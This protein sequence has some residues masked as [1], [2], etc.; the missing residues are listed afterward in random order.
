MHESALAVNLL[1][2]VASAAAANRISRVTRIVLR[3][4][5]MRM[6]VPELLAS[7]FEIAGVGSV[8][9]GAALEF[10]A[11]PAA[12]ICRACGARAGVE[13]W[14]F[15]CPSCGSGET[16]LES[17]GELDLVEMTGEQGEDA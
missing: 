4:G 6:V 12:M 5:A 17:G 9:E 3:V 1:D 2:A 11:V 13:D 14:V 10:I 7:A 8:A 16:T 15:F